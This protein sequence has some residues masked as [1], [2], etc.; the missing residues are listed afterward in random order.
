MHTVITLSQFLDLF[1]SDTLDFHNFINTAMV[2]SINNLFS[3]KSYMIKNNISDTKLPLL[4]NAFVTEKNKYLENFF[5]KSLKIP[6]SLEMNNP[7]HKFS[8]FE[9]LKFK[10][11]IRNIYFYDIMKNTKTIHTPSQSYFNVIIDLFK[12]NIIDYKLL[13]PSVIAC[14]ENK[15][16]GSMLSALYFRAS[17]MN[18]FLVYSLAMNSNIKIS[19]ILTPTLGWSSYMMGFIQTNKLTHYVGIDV[20][21][22]VCD[23]TKTLCKSINPA[24]QIDTY[25]CPSETLYTNSVFMNKYKNYFDFIFFSP[26]YFQLELY[27][28]GSQSTTNYKTLDQWLNNYWLPTIKL[29]VNCIDNDGTMCYIISNYK[30]NGKLVDLITPML[31]ITS[32]YFELTH[33]IHIANNN[34]SVTKHRDTCEI[35]YFFKKLN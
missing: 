30:L 24:I 9:N 15:K 22:K 13:T 7:S 34:I 17:I 12:F 16:F 14:I 23:N 18:P 28:G 19:K 25:C 27:D 32:T 26:P 6:S 20:I 10:N 35:A 8:N 5:N 29:C 33:K 11:I 31:A 21:Q 3:L 2:R 1:Q 4:Y